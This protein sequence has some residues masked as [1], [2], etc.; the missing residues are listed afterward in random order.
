MKNSTTKWTDESEANITGSF[1]DV[2]LKEYQFAV[3][4]LRGASN[5]VFWKNSVL[6]TFQCDGQLYDMIVSGHLLPQLPRTAEKK[7]LEERQALERQLNSVALVLLKKTLSPRVVIS[8]TKINSSHDLWEQLRI[9]YERRNRAE[10]TTLQHRFAKCVQGTRSSKE[11]FSEI[12]EI[13]G[14]LDMI[15]VKMC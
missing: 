13:I 11:Y 10:A 6:Q 7:L 9:K 5:Y 14:R 15:D 4:V 1:V 3:P 2:K 8:F 12:E